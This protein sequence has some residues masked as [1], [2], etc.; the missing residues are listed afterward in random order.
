MPDQCCG[1][2]RRSGLSLQMQNLRWVNSHNAGPS[3]LSLRLG[4]WLLSKMFKN[5]FFGTSGSHI[6]QFAEA[7]MQP[8][9]LQ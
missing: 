2:A 6:V 7:N 5:A 4:K 3:V 1:A 8:S 9:G